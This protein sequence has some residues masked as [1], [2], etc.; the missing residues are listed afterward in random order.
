[1]LIDHAQT[2]SWIHRTA[3]CSLQRTAC[4]VIA[5]KCLLFAVMLYR[6]DFD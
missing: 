5:T 6:L 4:L 2:T 1:V 3:L